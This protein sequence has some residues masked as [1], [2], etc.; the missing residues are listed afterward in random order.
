ME[1]FV[2]KTSDSRT[3]G[4]KYSSGLFTPHCS[5]DLNPSPSALT[6]Y[7]ESPLCSY[8]SRLHHRAMKWKNIVSNSGQG[9]PSE[10]GRVR[11]EGESDLYNDKQT[12][13]LPF[14]PFLSQSLKVCIF[15]SGDVA[16]NSCF[17]LAVHIGITDGAALAALICARPALTAPLPTPGGSWLCAWWMQDPV[18][19]LQP[20]ASLENNSSLVWGSLVGFSTT[21][22]VLCVPGWGGPVCLPQQLS[23]LLA[24]SMGKRRGARSSL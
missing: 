18:S 7:Q 3:R 14:V 13:L 15:S 6:S 24:V 2:K 11:S 23:V 8:L 16:S 1:R 20:L 17:A 22:M 5:P 10:T 12:Q 4:K 9:D 21:D 19:F